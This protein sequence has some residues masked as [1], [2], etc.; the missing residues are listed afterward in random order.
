MRLII[1]EK[2]SVGNSIAKVVKA[3][4]RNDGYIEG[5]E[6]IVSWCVGHLITPA[7]ASEYDP[8][9]ETWSKEDLPIIPEKWKYNV[10]PGTKKQF[11]TICRLMKR[12]DVDEI[13]EATDAGRE[14]E[15][16]FRLVYMMAKCSKPIKRLW[17]SSMEDNAIRKAFEHLKPGSEYNLLYKAALCRQKA[18]WLIGISGTRLFSTI[19]N[20]KLP[21]GRVM[22]PTLSMIIDRDKDIQDFKKEKYYTL[23]LHCVDKKGLDFIA[24]SERCKSEDE[25][26][27]IKDSCI[28]KPVY[29]KDL[30]TEQKRINPPVLFDLTTLQRT[31]NR[32]FGYTAQ[33]VLDVAQSLYEKKLLTYPRTDSSYITSD[34]TESIPPLIMSSA[35]VLP[36]HLDLAEEYS[37]VK[38]LVNDA[39]VTDHHALLP[40]RQV[41]RNELV[42]LSETE[43]NILF[44]VIVRLIEAVS[45]V[46]I[47][48]DT[49]AILVCENNEF[50]VKGRTI[51]Q[52]GW[53]KIEN[54]YKEYRNKDSKIKEKVVEQ[55]LPD[56]LSKETELRQKNVPTIKEG[57]TSPPKCFTE[58][59]L[60]SAMEHASEKEF[61]E[62]EN[63]EHTGIGTP[64]TRAS[65]IEKLIK[66]GLISRNGRNLNGT[67]KGKTLISILPEQLKSPSL[68]ADWEKKLK[69]VEQGKLEE[70]KFMKQIQNSL[71]DLVSSYEKIELKEN[72][73]TDIREIV[74]LC[75]KCGST[76][77]VTPHGYKC[78]NKNCSFM[79]WKNDRFFT[80]KKKEISRT[81]AKA[82]L[83]KG[84]AKIDGLWSETK[85]TYYSAT[86]VMEVGEK[87]INFHLEFGNENTET[88]KRRK[89]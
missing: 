16:I 23:N 47:H 17:L 49:T 51:L 21:V 14:G 88:A 46:E 5:S 8:K 29:V 69:D 75:P 30:K 52:S 50:K 1:T 89:R 3:Y 56:T 41:S 9:Y 33:K 67:I 60:L 72:E 68:T 65:V 4:H 11:E 73:M 64:A 31:C 80:S 61:A 7:D 38:V 37:K 39:K 28:G 13:I 22:T 15:L 79:L 57:F 87:Y 71:I 44:T 42:K 2:P 53:M 84:K 6:Y 66:E 26:K 45:S 54:L 48:K 70:D 19:Y 83:K 24:S 36:F 43:K 63:L 58:D 85:K 12:P 81:I 59:T 35:K 82:F 27:Q 76:V 40:T 34:M 77:V 62:I 10:I 86:V 32:F 55:N 20:K 18:D 74:G 25:V 78:K